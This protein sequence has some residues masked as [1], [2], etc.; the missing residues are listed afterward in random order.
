MVP[1]KEAASDGLYWLY[2]IANDFQ[3]YI[4]VMMPSIYIYLKKNKRNWIL[5]YLFCLI[6][7]SVLYTIIMTSI[8]GYSS[9]LAD[10]SS[11]MF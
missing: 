1:F 5:V 3:F 11:P 2:F 9:I 8:G 6:G 10:I 7:E 4:L